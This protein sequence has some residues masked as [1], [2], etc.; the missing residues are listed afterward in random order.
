MLMEERREQKESFTDYVNELKR[1]GR[2]R[3]FQHSK[4]IEFQ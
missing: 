3:R 1:R 4:G 2:T